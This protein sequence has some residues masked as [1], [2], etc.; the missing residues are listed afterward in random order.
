MS[1]TTAPAAV[2]Y[3]KLFKSSNNNLNHKKYNGQDVY[4]LGVSQQES[5]AYIVR[6]SD[7]FEFTALAEELS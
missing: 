3:V 6:A 5:N 7:G 4:V 2:D 1:T